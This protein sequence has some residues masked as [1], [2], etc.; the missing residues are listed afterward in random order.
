MRL[1]IF[2]LK[3]GGLSM[4]Q[5]IHDPTDAGIPEFSTTGTLRETLDQLKDEEDFQIMIEIGGEADGGEA[6]SAG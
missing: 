1:L 5:R 3:E 6:V 2:L 4:S